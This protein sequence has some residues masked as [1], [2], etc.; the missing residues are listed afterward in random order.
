MFKITEGQYALG[1][2]TVFAL[3]LFV[4]LPLLHYL[5]PLQ[6][7]T[8]DWITAVATAVDAVFTIVLAFVGYQ[9]VADA[10]ILQRAYLSV[11]P[12]GIQWLGLQ[13]LFIG[14]VIFKN[15]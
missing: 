2:L 10:R 14:Q 1:A 7:T 11:Q 13:Q 6:V 3:W 8:T 4:I 12:Q 5:G 9:Q 15:V